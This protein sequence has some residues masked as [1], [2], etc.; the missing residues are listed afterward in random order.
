M[1]GFR[2]EWSIEGEKQLSRRLEGLTADV[3]NLTVPFRKSADM[4]IG[5][6]SKDVFATEGAA[7]GERWQRLS[8]YTVA[9]KAR[10]GYGGKGILER[11]GKMRRSFTSVV[12]S[13]QAVIRNTADYF[14]YHQSNQPRKKLPRR[15][16][17]KLGEQQKEQVVKIFQRYLQEQ[18]AH[19]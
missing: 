1:A 17:M 11:T 13:D 18:I 19:N 12:A 7:I 14:K 4:L 10:L 15:V 6:F 9:Q 3:K 16:I 2:L 8:P 5:V